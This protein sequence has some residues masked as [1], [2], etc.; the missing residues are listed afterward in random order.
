MADRD[1]L[2]PLAGLRAMAEVQRAGLE[3]AATVVERMLELGRLG[4]RGPFPFPLPSDPAAGS[5]GDQ[6]RDRADPGREVRRLRGDAERMLEL[7]GE[8]MRLLLDAAAD[9]TEAS[10]GNRNGEPDRLLLGP[11]KPGDSVRGRTW[12]HVLDGP[13][14]APARLAATAFSA[15]DGAAIEAE[16]MTFDPPVL[17]TFALRSS[18]EIV[19]T[20]AVSARTPA[21]VY[22]GH[23]LAAGLPELSLAVRI[24]VSA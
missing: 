13:P 21:G 24:E 11:V 8:W 15:H 20:V 2:D 1:P 19:V 23:I 16:A 5:N 10:L 3:A 6:P 18:Q 22:H 14:T 17:D 4:T 9:S 7:W 12:L